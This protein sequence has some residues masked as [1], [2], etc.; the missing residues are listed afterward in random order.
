[1]WRCAA[2]A[3][4]GDYCAPSRPVACLR[5][6]VVYCISRMRNVF[7][8]MNLGGGSAKQQRMPVDLGGWTP[9][10]KRCRCARALLPSHSITG[11]PLCCRGALGAAAFRLLGARPRASRAV[12][13][14]APRAPPAGGPGSRVEPP[15]AARPRLVRRDRVLGR[16]PAD[17]PRARGSG[18]RGLVAS[19]GASARP[20]AAAA[21]RRRPRGRA[22]SRASSRS[23]A[24][25]HRELVLVERHDARHARRRARGSARQRERESTS[26]RVAEG[27]GP[28][29]PPARAAPRSTR[30]PLLASRARAAEV[31][32]R[33]ARSAFDA[34]TPPRNVRV[35]VSSAAGG[36]RAR[37][38]SSDA[39]ARARGREAPARRAAATGDGRRAAARRRR[40]VLPR[41]TATGRARAS[42]L[43]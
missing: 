25:R 35:D 19:A 22:P 37:R 2:C 5:F 3:A 16:R 7:M 29:S 33:A 17:V 11:P 27:G 13:T 43:P 14:S 15:R 18:H 34:P 26:T 24:G 10:L 1:M 39:R 28:C 20:C 8:Q 36:A 32:Q 23:R 30:R 40:T 41:M 9:L 21:R 12:V 42:S 4:V 31:P 6:Y 38:R